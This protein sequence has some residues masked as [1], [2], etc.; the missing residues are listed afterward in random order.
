[1][2]SVDFKLTGNNYRADGSVTILYDDLKI[3]FLEMDDNKPTDKKHITSFISNIIR[4]NSNPKK[5][6][7]VRVGEVH[8]ERDMN[9][10]FYNLIW[11]SVL[12]GINKTIGN[13]RK[14]KNP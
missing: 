12:E 2:R 6:E 3:D 7:E 10:S 11:K 9:R 14:M 4:K 5:D 8:H 13:K 1:L